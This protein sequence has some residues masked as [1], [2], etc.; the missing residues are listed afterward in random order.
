[1]TLKL[2]LKDA[3]TDWDP[4]GSLRWYWW[5]IKRKMAKSIP[6]AVG[7]TRSLCDSKLLCVPIVSILLVELVTRLCRHVFG[8]R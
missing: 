6:A 8:C 2:D 3:G 7:C 4:S 5:L 1:M